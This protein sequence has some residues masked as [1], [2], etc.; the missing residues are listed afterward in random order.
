MRMWEKMV[1]IFIW[2]SQSLDLLFSLVNQCPKISWSFYI[3]RCMIH[4]GQIC[5][6]QFKKIKRVVN[7]FLCIF[8]TS[9]T[10]D[11][12]DILGPN[13]IRKV[14]MIQRLA[15]VIIWKQ[16]VISS[17]YIKSLSQLIF[18]IYWIISSEKDFFY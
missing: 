15:Y 8:F 3:Y 13:F 9:T 10:L 12:H 16:K 7:S 2:S 4:N 14:G 17:F 11:N 6:N 18:F 1:P 5:L